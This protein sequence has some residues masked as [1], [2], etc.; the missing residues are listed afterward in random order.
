MYIIHLL[1]V[2]SLHSSEHGFLLHVIC[3]MFVSAAGRTFA[4]HS[5]VGHLTAVQAAVWCK[6]ASKTYQAKDTHP[7]VN[8]YFAL[9]TSHLD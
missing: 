7:M 4:N 9:K 1:S 8:V 5:H 2:A 3:K 6:H